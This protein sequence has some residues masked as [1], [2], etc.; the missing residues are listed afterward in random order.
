MPWRLGDYLLVERL[1]Q[2]GMADVYL[3]KT[4]GYSGANQTLAVKCIRP[5]FG[6]DPVFVRMFIDEAKLSV[7]LDHAN[8]AQTYE[9]GRIGTTYFMAMEYILGRDL[10]ALIDRV[11]ARGLEIPEPLALLITIKVCEGLDYAHRKTDPTGVPLRIVHRDVS[12]QNILVS[13][14]GEVKI[15]DFGI[16]KAATHASRSQAGVLKGKYGYMSPEQVRGMAVDERSDIFA[17]GVLLFELLTRQRLF[18]GGSDFSVLEK[19]RHSE[20]YPPT[21]LTPSV[22][23]EVETVVLRALEREP[24]RRFASASDMGD[25]LVQVML[26]HFGQPISRDLSRLVKDLFAAERHDDMRRLEDARKFTE[27]PENVQVLAGATGPKVGATDGVPTRPGT[28]RHSRTVVDT[29]PNSGQSNAEQSI[30]GQPNPEQGHAG[31]VTREE[32]WVDDTAPQR[33]AH[34]V[35]A[36]GRAAQR[37]TSRDGGLADDSPSQVFRLGGWPTEI[38][39]AHRKKGRPLRDALIVIAALAI[40][41]GLVMA[42]WFGTRLSGRAGRGGI[43]V[44]TNPPQA[45]VLL[46]GVRVGLTPFSSSVHAGERTVTIRKPGFATIFR[47]VRIGREKVV[48]LS[49]ALV[50]IN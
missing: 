13:Y 17:C 9:L 45:E 25:A 49:L 23:P 11:A 7:L 29:P 12:P 1:N 31:H 20:V 41:G 50:P 4:F 46:D 10:R 34:R 15:I 47:K 18:P 43:V 14:D 26:K 5:E 39:S 40:A 48:E 22:H 44:I 24:E 27:M 38:R 3:A 2:G 42:T 30:S 16:A 32:A 8:I 21:V 35:A 37:D 28:P 36:P 33:P 6:E 19:V